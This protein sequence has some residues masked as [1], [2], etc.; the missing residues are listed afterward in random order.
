MKKNFIIAL[1]CVALSF[2]ACHKPDPEPEPEDNVDYTENYVGNYIGTFDFVITSMNNQP[3]GLT[4]QLDNIS[5]DIAKG[6]EFNAITATV[7]VDNQMRQTTGTAKKAK[8]DFEPVHLVIDESHHANPYLLNLDLLMEGTKA[9]SDTL[10]IVGTVS[11]N[12]N[13]TFM[14]QETILNEVSGTL[15]GKLVKQ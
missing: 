9:D 11:G 6:T 8:A 14:G 15:S 3:S 1:C 5:M 2:T 10:N 7:T 4:Y 12:G 13:F